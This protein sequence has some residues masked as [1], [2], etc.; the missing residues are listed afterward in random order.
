MNNLGCHKNSNLA[1]KIIFEFHIIKFSCSSSQLVLTVRRVPL[2]TSV[3][4]A[5]SRL[6][7]PPVPP[8]AVMRTGFLTP[9][10]TVPKV[11]VQAARSLGNVSVSLV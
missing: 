3:P 10:E 9:S 7:P 5:L 4:P 6:T 2:D 8:A 11:K 1:P